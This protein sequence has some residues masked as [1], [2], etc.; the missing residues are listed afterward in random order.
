M[1]ETNKTLKDLIQLGLEIRARRKEALARES[2]ET[3]RAVLSLLPT[4]LAEHAQVEGP[5]SERA[6]VFATAYIEAPFPNKGSLN[7]TAQRIVAG[8]EV[9]WELVHYEA[10][11]PN[12]RRGRFDNL[13]EAVAYAAGVLEV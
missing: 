7:V 9:R 10:T 6:S 5:Y 2:A 8:S 3:A 11:A 4:A 13:P 1:N 12:G